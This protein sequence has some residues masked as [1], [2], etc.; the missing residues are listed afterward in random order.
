MLRP[1]WERPLICAKRKTENAKANKARGTCIFP[2][3]FS[4]G[5]KFAS[6]YSSIVFVMWED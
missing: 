1:F 3:L 6:M 2:E 4:A 5:V